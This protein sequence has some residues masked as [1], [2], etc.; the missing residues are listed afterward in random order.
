MSLSLL[1]LDQ[2]LVISIWFSSLFIDEQIWNCW[3]T[4]TRRHMGVLKF[5]KKSKCQ[6]FTIYISP[7]RSFHSYTYN[8]IS[9]YGRYIIYH[10]VSYRCGRVI[11]HWNAVRVKYLPRALYRGTARGFFLFTPFQMCSSSHHFFFFSFFLKK[12][13][14]NLFQMIAL[15]GIRPMW[16][17]FLLRIVDFLCNPLPNPKFGTKMSISL[18][19]Y[20]CDV[21]LFK[22]NIERDWHWYHVWFSSTHSICVWWDGVSLY[23]AGQRFIDRYITCGEKRR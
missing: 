16:L 15:K 1:R 21:I 11:L 20:L 18:Y 19:I 22:D 9:A 5:K 12:N 13:A 2:I 23:D 7:A 17:V 3:K 14:T 4:N 6:M 8:S 10:I